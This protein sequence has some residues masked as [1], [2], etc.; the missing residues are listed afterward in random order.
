MAIDPARFGMPDATTTGVQPGITLKPYT[1]PM[2][3]T[4]DG[5]V[6]ENVIINGML[7]VDADNVTIRN[8]VVQNFSWYGIMQTWTTAPPTSASRT[9]TSKASALPIRSALP[10]VAAALP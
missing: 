9:A 7:T 8:C 2:T 6:I 4:T 5:A 3:I 10:S 1:G